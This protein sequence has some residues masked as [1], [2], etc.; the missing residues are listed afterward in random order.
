MLVSI[1]HFFFLQSKENEGEVGI[2]GGQKGC[3]S[4]EL[5]R[6]KVRWRICEIFEVHV[7][8]KAM[9]RIFRIKKI[10]NVNHYKY[11]GQIM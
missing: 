11:V 7:L 3:E 9:H 10:R 8:I 1:F 4:N 2:D 6:G 5:W